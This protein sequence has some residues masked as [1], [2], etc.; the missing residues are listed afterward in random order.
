[1]E[2]KLHSDYKPTGDQPQAIEKLVKGHRYYIIGY[3]HE[4]GKGRMGVKLATNKGIDTLFEMNDFGKMSK[5]VISVCHRFSIEENI[6]RTI[7]SV[8]L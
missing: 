8:K 5:D 4:Y 6:G 7:K 3:C 1:M 2:F